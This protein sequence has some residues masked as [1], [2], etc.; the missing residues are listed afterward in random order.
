MS[1]KRSASKPK[2]EIESSGDGYYT[3]K[4]NGVAQVKTRDLLLLSK[5]RDSQGDRR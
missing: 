4:V 1:A 5:F 3:L 2:I